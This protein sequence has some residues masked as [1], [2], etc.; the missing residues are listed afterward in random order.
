MDLAEWITIAV[1]LSLGLASLGGLYRAG[2]RQAVLQG[3]L[4]EADRQIALLQQSVTG[5]TAGAVGMDR[6]IRRLE[7]QER[8]LSERQQAFENQQ[9]AE[10]PYSQAIRLVQQGSSVQRLVEELDLSESEA[11]LI[12]RLHGDPE[13]AGGPRLNADS[14]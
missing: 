1:A 10:Q 8:V 6:R 2:R 7:A 5:L 12:S 9:A 11:L 3:R 13:A 14:G 4:A